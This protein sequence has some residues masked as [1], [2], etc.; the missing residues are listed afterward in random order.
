MS[1]FLRVTLLIEVSLLCFVSFT[2]RRMEEPVMGPIMARITAVS[3]RMSTE[4]TESALLAAFTEIHKIDAL[5]SKYKPDSDV[6]RL[7]RSDAGLWVRVDPMTFT[8]LEESQRI[9]KLTKGAFDVTALPLS[10]LWGFWPPKDTD[11]PTDEEIRAVLAHVGCEKLSLERSSHRLMKSDPE[12]KVDLGGIAKG[13]AVDKAIEVL[14]QKG[15][16]NALVEIGGEARAIGKNKSGKPWRIGVLHP[17]KPEY[18]T[19]LELS[20]KAVATSGDYMNFVVIEG[21]RYCHLMNPRTGK[22]ISNDLC[23]VTVIAD[24][25]TQADALATAISVMGAEEGL[26][27]IESL[28]GIETII[29]KRVSE[30]DEIKVYISTGLKGLDIARECEGIQRPVR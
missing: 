13:Y 21:K 11:V 19:V 4:K 17:T 28:P 25:C 14:K 6:S 2:V 7:N 5:M 10:T 15:L 29:T 18:L 22:P 1:F 26:K 23:S 3:T 9:A 20:N 16:R 8:V 12:T 27:L 24:N 30:A